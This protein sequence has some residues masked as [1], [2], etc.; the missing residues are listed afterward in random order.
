M[1]SCLFRHGSSRAPSPLLGSGLADLLLQALSDI[2]DALVLVGI[3]RTKAAH[4]RR[5]LAALLAVNTADSDAGL[6]GID[7]HV[8]AG[9]QRILDGMRVAQREHHGVLTL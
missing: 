4:V 8:N 5:D 1:T 7:G 2:T 9:R 3:R 6:L